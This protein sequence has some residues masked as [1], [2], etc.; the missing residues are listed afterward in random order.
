M[1]TGMLS[2]SNTIYF[3]CAAAVLVAL[4]LMT[5]WLHW[6]G[7]VSFPWDFMMGYY[8]TTAYWITSI[9][10]GEWPHWVPYQSMGYPLAMNAQT[11]LFYPPLWFFPSLH[12]QYTLHAANIAQ[13]L[14]VLGGG[15]GMLLL[16]HAL[17]RSKAVALCAAVSF[18]LYGGF[19]TNSEHV[20]IVRAFALL[21]WVLWTLS[22]TGERSV[23]MRLFGWGTTTCLQPRNILLP[24]ALF[25]YITGSY[26]GN[27]IAGMPMFATFIAVQAAVR[28][29]HAAGRAALTDAATQ[30][31]LLALGVALSAVYL[32][33]LFFLSGELTRTSN[34]ASLSRWYLKP[35]DLLGLLYSSSALPPPNSQGD[36]S[37]FG[38]QVPIALLPFLALVRGRDVVRLAPFIAIGLLALV[39]AVDVFRPV[40]STLIE[41]FPP[42]GYSRFP[43]GD[44][45]TFV[46]LAVL[47]LALAGLYRL[48]QSQGAAFDRA[49]RRVAMAA[50]GLAA[51]SLACLYLIVP[52][53]S[54]AHF[55]LVLVWQL[56]V[57]VG[58][59]LL[60]SLR[61]ARARA[62]YIAVFVSVLCIAAALPVLWDMRSFWVDPSGEAYVYH[63]HGLNGLTLTGGEVLRVRS[64]FER[65]LTARPARE[66]IPESSLLSWRG[67][68]DGSFMMADRGKTISRA[69]AAVERSPELTRFMR[70]PSRLV[71]V[72]CA[73][74]SCEGGREM[75][76]AHLDGST[77]G[78]SYAVLSYGRNTVSYRVTSDRRV[79]VIE[80]ELFAPGWSATLHGDMRVQPVKVNGALRGW[81]VPAGD[82]VLALSYRTPHLVSGA[83]LSLAV[84]AVLLLTLGRLL[85]ARG[86]S[87]HTAEVKRAAA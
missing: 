78:F 73:H 82:H 3:G 50:A 76:V 65:S 85:R 12:L 57:V 39:M 14:H 62:L 64:V 58:V 18:H 56:A 60:T 27:V 83:L 54:R 46:Y 59:M 34:F 35:T 37:M 4:N 32:W 15:I 47:M 28:W 30:F 40:S 13:A 51:L 69:R 68:I 49:M 33:P 75:Q 26:M 25:C 31:A 86:A 2:A 38:M 5:F 9:G 43:A 61:D 16:A 67:Y 79:L 45:R 87:A 17:F 52:P 1:L 77:P 55:S 81:V 80:N 63:Q 19:Y 6:A 41:L 29:A 72:D 84:L 8:A 21:P 23:P 24:L 71:G 20:D 7:K 70:E 10:A 48:S 44:Y 74:V 22:V 53:A 42:L 11:G 36:I 66:S